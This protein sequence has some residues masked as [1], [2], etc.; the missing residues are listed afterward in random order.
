MESMLAL[1]IIIISCNTKTQFF[2]KFHLEN[3]HIYYT[4][5]FAFI[6]S[7]LHNETKRQSWTTP[8]SMKHGE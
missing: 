2:L 6:W 3:Q 7:N 8:K 1:E 5:P 4:E